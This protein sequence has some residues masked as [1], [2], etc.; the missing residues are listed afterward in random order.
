M[1]C[2]FDAH[3]AIDRGFGG[4]LEVLVVVVVLP[5]VTGTVTAVV[6]VVPIY[7]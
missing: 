4:L 5:V 7:V 1:V 2:T 3:I 6:D